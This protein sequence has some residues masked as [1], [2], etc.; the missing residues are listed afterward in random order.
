LELRRN[1][2]AAK[3]FNQAL[4]LNAGNLEAMIRLAELNIGK[5]RRSEAAKLLEDAALLEP[6]NERIKELQDRAA[7]KSSTPPDRR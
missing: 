3:A 4:S 2:D 6:H 7:D 5:N 1:D